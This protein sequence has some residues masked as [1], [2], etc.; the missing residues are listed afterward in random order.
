MR[1]SL[2][3]GGGGEKVEGATG[4]RRGRERRCMTSVT[5]T[6][7]PSYLWMCSPHHMDLLSLRLSESVR[8]IRF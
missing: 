3:A 4:V 2:S 6:Q 1:R 7:M 8:I 5:M